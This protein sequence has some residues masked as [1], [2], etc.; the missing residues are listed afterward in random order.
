MFLLHLNL[1]FAEFRIEKIVCLSS[2]REMFENGSQDEEDN[3]I[4][5]GMKAVKLVC[6]AWRTGPASSTRSSTS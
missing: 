6:R 2:L 5:T 1:N 3:L 4:T